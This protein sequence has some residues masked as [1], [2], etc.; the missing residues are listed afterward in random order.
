M[1]SPAE[2]SAA[3]EKRRLGSTELMI[4]PIGL[5]AWA[6]GGGDWIF[7]WGPQNDEESIAAIRRAI[8]LGINWIDTAAVY[9]LGHSEEVIARALAD[10]PRGERP[11]VFTKCSLVWDHEGNV[12]HCLKRDS[13]RREMEESLRRL[14]VETIDLYQV[15]WPGFPAGNESPDLEEGWRA[16]AELKQEGKARFIG[17]SNFNP[18]QME[19]AGRIAQLSSLQPPY[20]MLSRGIEKEVL[21][22]CA[23][24]G[25]G[26]IVY[27][28]MHAGLLSGAMTRERVAS[29]PKND[30][31][32]RFNTAFQ[33]PRLTRNLK[34][35]EKIRDISTRHGR[36]PGEVA[37]AWTLRVPSVTAAI[38]GARRPSQV[39]G[40]VG[41][42]EFRL[43]DS[44]VAEIE[45]ILAD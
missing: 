12:S 23:A 22:Y 43:S 32:I 21:P 30:W 15:H 7:G 36:S 26:V 18:A 4:T 25:I 37:I 45:E 13:I 38:V 16:V 29:L 1:I 3:M 14:R 6:M 11:L 34:I 9:G 44:E 27:S 5:G 19:R 24:Q 41:A 35:V 28:P 17:V 40:F 8:G 20:S 31:R 39:D 10:I 33:E 2:D 42:A